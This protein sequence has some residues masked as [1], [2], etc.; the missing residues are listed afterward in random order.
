MLDLEDAKDSSP[1]AG[2]DPM[3]GEMIESDRDI[4]SVLM[5]FWMVAV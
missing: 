5:A 4:A 3:S 2:G 1:V